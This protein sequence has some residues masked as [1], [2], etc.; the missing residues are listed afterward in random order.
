MLTFL[1]KYPLTVCLSAFIV[2]ACLM[3]I[4]EVPVAADVPLFDKWTHML[5]YTCLCTLMWIE[6]WRSHKHDA[7]WSHLNNRLSH[8]I[9]LALCAPL[10]LSGVLELLQAYATTY[11]S[12]EWLDFF[13]NA[14]GVG[15]GNILGI[16][17]GNYIKTR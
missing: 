1:K 16:S 3:P 17:C 13:A 5:M 2:I 10:C 9:L 15:I 11:R 8:I 7:V 4:P 6:Y 14:I 12:G